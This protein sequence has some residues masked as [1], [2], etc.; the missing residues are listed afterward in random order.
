MTTT[1]KTTLETMTDLYRA[2]WTRK[3]EADFNFAS[4]RQYLLGLG[5]PE[6]DMRKVA[7]I[8]PHH[9]PEPLPTNP[10]VNTP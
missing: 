2:A 8:F 9:S 1:A 5:F 3:Q 6:P 10:P 7:G 4:T